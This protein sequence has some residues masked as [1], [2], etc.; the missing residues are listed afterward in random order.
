[1]LP[2]RC[3]CQGVPSM[4]SDRFDA[5][6]RTLF[7]RIESRRRALSILTLGA[8]STYKLSR[9]A[10]AT[11][12][13]V[14]QARLRVD[15]GKLESSAITAKPVKR[16]RLHANA[17]KHRDYKALQR[18]LKQQGFQ[19]SHHSVALA[20]YDD[21]RFLRKVLLWPYI[22]SS[23][24]DIANV[25][26]VIHSSGGTISYAPVYTGGSDN[27]LLIAEKDGKNVTTHFPPAEQS[28][29][30][31]SRSDGTDPCPTCLNTC[32]VMF[33]V[34]DLASIPKEVSAC[35]S[36]AAVLCAPTLVSAVGYF[37]CA[38]GIGASC[39]IILETVEGIAEDIT[40]DVTCDI[41]NQCGSTCT[42]LLDAC[43]S[44]GECCSS[45]STVCATDCCD[46]SP[47]C[48]L[49]PG[50]GCL[51]DCDCC[52]PNGFVHKCI[53]GFCTQQGICEE[54]ASGRGQRSKKR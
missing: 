42:P 24:G 27:Y 33:T 45:P 12:T 17:A 48:C 18:F 36:V 6:T 4:D 14:Q 2:C 15:K 31:R 23:T 30:L 1:M 32:D 10:S 29:L 43:S 41:A 38:L 5:L 52:D 25:T 22:N 40:C 8:F 53:N 26:F 54:E 37:V 28:S 13:K 7:T 20:L 34:I 51:D 3:A 11:R 49:L 9:D 19:P 44:N 39:L 50:Q 47:H 46:A 16:S 35:V 21:G